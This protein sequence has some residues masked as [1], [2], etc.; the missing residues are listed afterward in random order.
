M[1]S[2]DHVIYLWDGDIYRMGSESLQIK[3]WFKTVLI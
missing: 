3:R 2:S 1:I